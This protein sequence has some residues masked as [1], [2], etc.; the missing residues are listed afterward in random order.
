MADITVRDTML[1][2]VSSKSG[3]ASGLTGS[4]SADDPFQSMAATEVPLSPGN[5]ASSG[6]AGPSPDRPVPPKKVQLDG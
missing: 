1:K 3:S 5:N 4:T 6:A 2:Q